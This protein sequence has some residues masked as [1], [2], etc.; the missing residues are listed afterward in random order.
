MTPIRGEPSRFA[1]VAPNIKIGIV[2]VP[3]PVAAK[4]KVCT[5]SAVRLTTRF[6]LAFVSGTGYAPNSFESL[7]ATVPAGGTVPRTIMHRYFIL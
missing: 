3:D 7:P 5:L 1:F 2:T 6:E 4:D